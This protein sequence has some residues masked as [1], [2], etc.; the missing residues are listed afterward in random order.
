MNTNEKYGKYSPTCKAPATEQV[1]RKQLFKQKL[2]CLGYHNNQSGVKP[3]KDKTEA[4]TNL[5]ATKNV[6]A[7]KSF[8]GSIQHLSNFI[9]NF[10]KKTDRMKRLKKEISWEWKPEIYHDFENFKKE[11]TESPCLAHFD[12]KKDNYVTTDACNTGLGATLWQKDGEIFRPIAFASKF[13]SD[14]ERK[15]ATN[16]L[17]LLGALWGLEYFIYYV[18]EKR[19]N[20]LTDHQALQPLL[21]RNRAYKQY[22][23]RLTRWLVRLCHFD[24]NVKYT[25]GKNI[26]LTDYLSRHPI[27]STVENETESSVSRHLKTEAE[28]EFV[29]NQI[30]GLFGFIDTNESIN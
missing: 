13:L 24:V 4:T 5:N 8:L 19:V 20:L 10:S 7:R 14:C 11:I 16:E 21:K 1:K 29:I 15:Y 30:H 2:T 25:A 26:A 22:S 23:V 18:Y 6:K 12:P 9:N 27:V 28:D 17:E 3:R